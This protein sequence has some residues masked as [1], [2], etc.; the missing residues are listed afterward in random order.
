MESDMDAELRFHIEAFAE[1]LAQNGLPREEATRRARI[2]FGGIERA[3]EECR[4]ARGVNFIESLIQ[5]LRFGARML[6]KSPGFTSVAVLTLALGIGANTAIFT[7]VNTVL[8]HPLPYPDSERIVNISRRTVGDSVPMFTFWLQNNPGLDDLSAYQSGI[9]MNLAGRDRPEFIQATKVSRNYFNLFA[10]NPLLGRTFTQDEDRSAGPRVLVLSYG[11]WQRKFGGDASI[12]NQSITL[13]GAPYTVIGVLSPSFRPQPSTDVWIPLQADASSTDQAHI[14]MVSARLPAG[15][16]L[17]QANSQMAVLGKRYVQ[18][19]PEQLGNDDDIHVTPMQSQITRDVRSPLLILLG[20]V[21]VVLLIACANV[22]NLLL[23]RAATRKGEMVLRAALGAGR[24]RIVRQ[25]LAESLLLSLSG[26]ILGLAL[27]SWG[28]R[29]LL[30]FTPGNLPRVQEMAAIAALD[31]WVAG[32]TLL[33]AA[34]TGVLFG[35]YPAAQLSRTELAATFK[36]SAGRAGASPKHN[37]IRRVLTATEVAMAVALLCGALLLIRSFAAMHS[38]NLGF[39]PRNLLTMEV[40]LT[41]PGYEKSIDVDR[42]AR[43]FVDHAERIPGV[44]SAAFANSLPLR[45][46]QD[47]IFDIPGHPP[48][49]GFKFTGDVQWRFVSAHYFDV[50]RIPLIAGRP[51]RADETGR[52]L[53]INQTMA[54]QFWPGANP[55]GQSIILGPGLGKAFEQGAAEIVGIVGDV[56]ERLDA[57]P[58]PIMYQTPAQIPDAAMVLVNGL[59]SDAV[60]VRAR[61]GVA[62]VSLS[63][64]VQ[65]ALLV[66]DKLP[67]TKIATMDQAMLSS[68]ERQNFN[69][70]LLALFAALALFLAAVGIYGVTSYSVEQRTQEIGIRAALGAQPREI[71]RLVLS[72]AFRMTLTGIVAGLAAAFA[73]TRLLSAQLFGVRP[74]DPATFIAVPAILLVVSLAAAWIP[75]RRAMRVDPMAALRHE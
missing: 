42:L 15:G 21:T 49:A 9:G 13:G 4:E 45:G 61:P 54:R 35:L 73:L 47:M 27:G 62:P 70:L 23:A 51:L 40:S 20:T 14:V 48:L 10:A 30:R 22:A 63:N 69:F 71:L 19:H 1:D 29:A 18:A 55:V 57:E 8:L 58:P 41:G 66:G 64:K 56:R 7:V 74:T 67:A 38:V 16:S 11:L 39:D 37:R 17:G 46:T 26:A 53:L 68:T 25:L 3:K 50:L 28:L 2:E 34:G 75:A 24:A 5:D 6:R 12:L 33:L 59:Q 36:E 31:P 60:V 52:T 72:E 65:E 43:Q 44:E 32:F